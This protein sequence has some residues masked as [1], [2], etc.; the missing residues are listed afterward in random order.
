MR[1]R[2]APLHLPSVLHEKPTQHSK[3]I[4]YSWLLLFVLLSCDITFTL[5]STR[6]A[7]SQHYFHSTY[8][9][10]SSSLLYAL[11]SCSITFTLRS[12]R[13]ANSQHYFHSTYITYTSI[14][15]LYI[16]AFLHDGPMIHLLST[17]T[18]FCVEDLFNIFILH[19]QPTP[20]IIS[21]STWIVHTSAFT[22]RIT[23]TLYTHS[24]FTVLLN[25]ILH[26]RPTLRITTMLHE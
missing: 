9:T 18:L 16:T 12:A 19:V 26:G 6:E 5:C 1:Y 22:L 14:I 3:Y 23:T 10:Y 11:P 21:I 24:T 15:T 25:S 4:T 8:I 7:Y 20:R 2:H 13:V 17:L